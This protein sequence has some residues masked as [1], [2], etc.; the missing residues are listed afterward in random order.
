MKSYAIPELRNHFSK[1]MDVIG[2]MP[3]HRCTCYTSSFDAKA[4][5][6]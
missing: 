4:V 5:S 6:C 2:M 3:V 1:V